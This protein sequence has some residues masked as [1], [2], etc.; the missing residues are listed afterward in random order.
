M[1]F[2]LYRCENRVVLKHL[3]RMELNEKSFNVIHRFH[4]NVL[5]ILFKQSHCTNPETFQSES[6]INEPIHILMYSIIFDS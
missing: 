6:V 1:S 3:S 5:D 4:L 2:L